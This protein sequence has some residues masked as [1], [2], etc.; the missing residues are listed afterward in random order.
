MGQQVSQTTY[1]TLFLQIGSNPNVFQ[2]SNP[3]ATAGLFYLPD[4]RGRVPIALDNLGGTAAGR[5]GTAL[6]TDGGT[7]NG[8]ALGSFGGSQ[9]HLQAIAEIRSHTHTYNGADIATTSANTTWSGGGSIVGDGHNTISGGAADHSHTLGGN[10]NVSSPGNGGFVPTNIVAF[11]NTGN[12]TTSGSN[13]G[14]GY[15]IPV[16]GSCGGNVS[17]SVSG[18]VTCYGAGSAN[19]NTNAQGGTNAMA[20]LQPSLMVG[21]LIR[22]Q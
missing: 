13:Y 9:S 4:L 16:S 10:P 19:L 11:G 18:T 6:A 12:V 17:V 21:A 22:I 15:S 20:W 1:N 2:G 5:I 3:P 8:Q 14:G 7:V